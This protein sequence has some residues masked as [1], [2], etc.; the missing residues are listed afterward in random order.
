MTNRPF[1]DPA[2]KAVFNAYPAGLRRSL[3]HLRNLIF[4]TGEQTKGA[5]RIVETLKWRQPAYLTEN[6]RSG[7]TIRIDAV[8]DGDGSYAMYFHCQTNLIDSFR[9][10]FPGEFTF[11]GNR[12]IRFSSE[13][14]VPEDALKRCIALA[15]TYHVRRN[16]D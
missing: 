5:G 8:K 4:V 16:A 7:T 15:L 14:P 11:E 12:A 3:L 1:Q 2:V 9:S 6:P 13:H 10:L